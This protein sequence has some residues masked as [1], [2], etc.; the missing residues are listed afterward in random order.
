M[1]YFDDRKVPCLAEES[2]LEWS[3]S[4]HRQDLTQLLT[5]S[6]IESYTRFDCTTSE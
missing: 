3:K 6:L 5:Q 1:E 4:M 2:S